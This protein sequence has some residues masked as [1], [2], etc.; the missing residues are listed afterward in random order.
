VNAQL[1]QLLGKHAEGLKVGKKTHNATVHRLAHPSSG[2]SGLLLVACSLGC[3][4][5]CCTLRRRQLSRHC[6]L[7]C[8]HDMNVIHSTMHHG[9]APT[10]TGSQEQAGSQY[11]GSAA[12]SDLLC[13]L[14]AISLLRPAH[15]PAAHHAPTALHL[16][17]QALPFKCCSI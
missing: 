14:L 12:R 10:C 7:L 4:L 13:L 17:V 16:R 8:N 6:V 11:A 1:Q 9:S 15:R 5:L 3:S 2:G